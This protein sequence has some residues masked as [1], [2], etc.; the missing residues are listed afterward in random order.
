MNVT[1][2]QEQRLFVIP[3][4]GGYT[5]LGF[6]VVYDNCLELVKRIRQHHIVPS[7]QPLPAVEQADV[8]TIGQY[9]QYQRLLN[10]VGTR[11]IGT[12]FNHSTPV[13]VRQVLET[14][15]KEGGRVRLFYGDTK[16]GRS[17]L[18]EFDM[19]GRVG[20]SRGTLQIPLLIEDGEYGGPGILDSCIVRI[21]DAD[22]RKELYRHRNFHVPDM[23]I[24]PAE[25]T[26]KAKGYSHGVWVVNKEGVAENHA[27]FKTFGK[28]AQ[29]VAFMAGECTEQPE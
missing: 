13:K 21:L 4:G 14:Y 25:D 23:E 6:D 19:V 16:T 8:G 15:R 18:D 5:C 12:W 29:W 28:A 24:R 27:N 1:V 2:N 11:K 10:I 20:R 7:E 26:V 9:A 17:W 22:T 3:S